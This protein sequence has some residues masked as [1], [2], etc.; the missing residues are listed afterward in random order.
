MRAAPRTQA[1]GQKRNVESWRDYRML[2]PGAF[3]PA[4]GVVSV[5]VFPFWS[6][7]VCHWRQLVTRFF[8]AFVCASILLGVAAHP[9]HARAAATAEKSPPV[10]KAAPSGPVP[11]AEL[12]AQAEAVTVHLREIAAGAAA[13]D[14][15]T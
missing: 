8:A 10:D 3:F 14:A 5:T 13:N 15:L 7:G 4:H 9:H 6:S 1:R 2:L 11:L 12:S